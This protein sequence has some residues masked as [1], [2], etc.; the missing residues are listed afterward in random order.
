MA[1]N[2]TKLSEERTGGAAKLPTREQIVE[3]A[4]KVNNLK[5]DMDA[6]RE[7][8]AAIEKAAA[9]ALNINL[10]AFKD[11]MKIVRMEAAKADHYLTHFDHIR[12]ALRV[13]E[14]RTAQL[15]GDGEAA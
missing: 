10:Q 6:V 9:E 2:V 1:E 8:K 5:A 13:D 7:D 12:E 3:L 11:V 15:F 4:A 14:G